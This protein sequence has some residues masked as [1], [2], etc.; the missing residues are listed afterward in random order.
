MSRILSDESLQVLIF[1]CGPLVLLLVVFI[2]LLIRSERPVRFPTFSMKIKRGGREQDWILYIAG[3]KAVEFDAWEGPKRSIE[4]RLPTRLSEREL[5]SIVPN[6]AVGLEKLRYQYLI[7]RE[8]E[9]QTIPDDERTEAIAELHQIGVDVDKHPDQEKLLQTMIRI[10]HTS[11]AGEA[12]LTFPR[13]LSLVNKATKPQEDTEVLACRGAESCARYIKSRIFWYQ[14]GLLR[15][16]TRD[17]RRL[18]D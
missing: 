5:S 12:N 10:E 2:V 8:R 15:S 1:V 7:Y 17:G 14:G 11:S 13:L 18:P 9:A 16:R 4:V 6:L 3:D